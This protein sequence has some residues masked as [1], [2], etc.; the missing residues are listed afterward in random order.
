MAQTATAAPTVEQAPALRIARG[1]PTLATRA[2]RR[3][4]TGSQSA[5]VRAW[6]FD[7]APRTVFWINDMP[8]DLRPSASRVLH[9]MIHEYDAIDRICNGF[10]RRGHIEP[11]A[12]PDEGYYDVAHRAMAYAGAGSGFAR[13]SALNEVGWTTQLPMRDT[14]SVVGRKPECKIHATRFVSSLNE[15]RRKL[16]WAE[17]SLIE[18]TLLSDWAEITQDDHLNVHLPLDCDYEALAWRRAIETLEDGRTVR[19]LGPG[20]VLRGPQIATVAATEP[21]QPPWF[22]RRIADIV[23]IVGERTAHAN[24]SPPLRYA[25]Q[26]A[27][28]DPFAAA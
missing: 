14:I 23:D 25:C 10:Y 4:R 18:A 1:L 20:T 19:R 8:P 21:D 28:G 27:D 13:F 24:P 11:G 22:S 17:V 5:A 6:V 9:D 15:G 3:P 16:T 2:P 7:L 26:P 12:P